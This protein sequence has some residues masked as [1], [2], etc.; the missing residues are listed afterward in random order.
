MIRRKLATLLDPTRVEASRPHV[1]EQTDVRP[2]ADDAE[3][4]EALRTRAETLSRELLAENEPD[5][6]PDEENILRLEMAHG[7]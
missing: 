7:E 5:Y 2:E 6:P 4:L 3:R 1:A